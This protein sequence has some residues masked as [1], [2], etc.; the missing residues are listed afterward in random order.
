M[1]KSHSFNNEADF[2]EGG[3]WFNDQ[4]RRICKWSWDAE[5]KKIY[6]ECGIDIYSRDLQSISDQ[7]LTE[8][9]L[10]ERLPKLALELAE[11]SI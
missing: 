9:K 5:S 2:T 6:V 10:K 8:E 1:N 4:G 3:Q 7:N 11:K